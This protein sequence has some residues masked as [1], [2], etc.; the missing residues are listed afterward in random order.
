MPKVKLAQPDMEYFVSIENTRYMRWQIKLLQESMKWLGIED[1]LLVAW[2]EVP[3][4][5]PEQISGRNFKHENLGQQLRYQPVN[6]PFGLM[7][8]INKGLIR[9]PFTVIDPDMV[10]RKPI[11]VKDAPVAA[12]YC[13]HMELDYW[14]KTANWQF[15]KD[16]G[17]E[18]LRDSWHPVGY[19]YQFNDVP[20]DVFEEMYHACIDLVSLYQPG[21]GKL[22]E[23]FY[24]VR[25]MLAFAIPLANHRVEIVTD[26]QTALDRKNSAEASLT[27]S[28]DA[29]LIHY[30]KSYKPYFD[31]S[32]FFGVDELPYQAIMSI[33]P[34]NELVEHMQ[35]ITERVINGNSWK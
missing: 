21:D 10:F 24:W 17:L 3:G 25:E 8:A 16:M 30:W 5:R 7:Q 4:E 32:K 9:Q 29:C 27:D 11:S 34:E 20:N 14:E 35:L 18:H 23:K 31:K 12:Q 2:A 19:V 26:F 22:N 6:K 13:W 1:K 28:P 33:P 15:L